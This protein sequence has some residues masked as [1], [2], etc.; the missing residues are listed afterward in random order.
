MVSLLELPLPQ[1]TFPAWEPDALQAWRSHT[2]RISALSRAPGSGRNFEALL[3]HARDM[4]ITGQTEAVV[5]RSQHRRFFRAVVTAWCDDAAL[6]QRTLTP[7]LLQRLLPPATWSRLTT[8]T[9]ATLFMEH[10]DH[11]DYWHP[12]LFDAA[13]QMV[14]EA[15]STPSRHGGSD[16][17]DALRAHSSFLLEL[18]GPSRLATVLASNGA[19]LTEWMRSNHLT[20]Y[21]DSRFGRLARDAFYLAWIRTADP[22]QGDHSLLGTI[23]EEVVARQRI[24]TTDVDGRFFGHEVLKAL[25]E[26]KTRN[27]STAWVAGVLGIGGDPRMRQTDLWQVWWSKVPTDHVDRAARWMRGIDLKAFLNGVEQYALETA[28]EDMQRMLERRKRLL[29][30]LYEQDRVDDVRLIL[31]DE[32]RRWITRTVPFAL[33]VA[34][35]RGYARQDTAVIYVDCGDFSLVEG[36]HNFKL[37]VYTGGQVEGISARRS[38]GF[39]VDELRSDLP[40]RHKARHGDESHLDVI[41]HVGGEWIRKALDY[42]WSKGVRLD[43]RSLMSSNDFAD[44]S[45]RRASAQW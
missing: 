33:D 19:D 32:I 16:L 17:V 11:L 26:A 36:S 5:E 28:N 22:E 7:E 38:G 27:P 3:Q 25:T 1:M 4:L 23:S 14:L 18:D 29:L 37:H 20:A 30:G 24:E 6:V 31:G 34:R 41:H 9:F 39:T 44:L 42:L 2:E 40:I 10:F 45:R 21:L 43:E 8:I 35:L 15:S 12:G 13:R